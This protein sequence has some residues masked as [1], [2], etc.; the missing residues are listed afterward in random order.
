M[1]GDLIALFSDGVTEAQDENENEFGET[2]TADF[3]RTIAHEP[4]SVI[5]EKVFAELDRFAGNAPQYD[6]ITL[7]VVKRSLL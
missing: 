4:A 1:P 5:V 2:N 6:D 3:I 7:M